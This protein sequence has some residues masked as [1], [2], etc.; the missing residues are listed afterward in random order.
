MAFWNSI[1]KLRLAPMAEINRWKHKIFVMP[2]ESRVFHTDIDPRYVNTGH[3]FNSLELKHGIL[4]V[5]EVV[6]VPGVVF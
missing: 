1:P 3:T 2:A 6:Q 4:L 5:L